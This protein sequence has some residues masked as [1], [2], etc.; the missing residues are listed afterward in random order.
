MKK[1]ILCCTEASFLS[2]GYATYGLEVQKRLNS[3]GKYELAELAAFGHPS[4]Q[5]QLSLPWRYYGNLPDS[6]N[7]QAYQ[8]NPSNRFGAYRFESVCLDF[9]P[10]IVWDFRDW[11]MLEYSNRSAFHPYYNIAFMPT[12]DSW[13]QDEEWMDTFSNADKILTYTDWSKDVLSRQSNNR[14]KVAG[15][16]SPAADY[17]T[18]CLRD[19]RK[20]KNDLGFDPDVTII[21]TVMRNQRRKLYPDL[22][23]SF[24][25]FL[26]QIPPAVAKK[27]F[28]YIHCCNPDVGWNIPK[29]INMFGLSSK[30]MVTYYCKQC[31]SVFSAFY[32]DTRTACIKCSGSA[33]FPNVKDGISTHELSK[34]MGLFDL[35][36]QYSICE[37]FGI[38]MVEAAACGV[39]VAAVD[40]SAMTDVVRKVGGYPIRVQRMYMEPETH[41]WRAL[42]DNEHLIQILVDFMKL[43]DGIRAK[44]GFESRKKVE[45]EYTWEKAA[46]A[47]ADA[48]DSIDKKCLPWNASA[49]LF[50]PVTRDIQSIPQ[51]MSNEQFVLWCYTNIVGRPELANSY[52]AARIARDLNWE[53]QLIK[54]SYGDLSRLP[55]YRD[56]HRNDALQDLLNLVDYFNFWE[57]QRAGGKK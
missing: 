24:A 49:R 51:E 4:D 26:K 20:H 46:K 11:W 34:I 21:G 16:A 14:I 12:V 33:T 3:T 29:L 57:A 2:T 48:F 19:R 36:V 54:D 41:C 50:T 44:K 31:K 5:R 38:P 25:E 45:T 40:Y 55:S 35:Y 47:W 15:V 23:K 52:M 27:V 30:V 17:K 39:P 22:F 8:A 18:Y 42:P 10:D 37:G 13:P 7:E 9:K 53:V 1:R 43:P 28:L 56:Y 6:E 32:Q